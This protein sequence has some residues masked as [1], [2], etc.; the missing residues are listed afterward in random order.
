MLDRVILEAARLLRYT[1]RGVGEVAHAT[2]YDD[3]LYFS[4]AFKRRFGARHALAELG[5][6][7]FTALAIVHKH[8][9]CAISDIAQRLSVDLSVASRQ[10][11]ALVAAGYAAREPDPEDRRAHR[12]TVTERGHA[13]A[14]ASRTAAWSRRSPARSRTGRRRRSSR[15]PR[16]STGCATTSRR[17][18][19]PDPRRPAHEHRPSGPRPARSS[20]A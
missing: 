20:R 17:R 5:T 8:G 4:R 11:A 1:D 14:D 7:G 2:G 16:G 19:T 10:V 12:I 15:S 3:P 9:P 13:G 18:R 6:Q